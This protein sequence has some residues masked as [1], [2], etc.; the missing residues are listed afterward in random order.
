MELEVGA[1]VLKIFVVRKVGGE[2]L[3]DLFRPHRHS[4]IKNLTGFDKK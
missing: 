2:L 3:A 4:N 1:E